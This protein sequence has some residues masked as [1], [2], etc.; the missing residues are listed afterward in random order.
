VTKRLEYER[1]HRLVPDIVHVDAV[2]IEVLQCQ[3]R[4]RQQVGKHDRRSS[5]V[6][7]PLSHLGV[8]DAVGFVEPLESRE[9]ASVFLHVALVTPPWR[10][11]PVVL[12]VPTRPDHPRRGRHQLVDEPG[13][14]LDV[15]GVLAESDLVMCV[16]EDHQNVRARVGEV[17]AK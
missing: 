17:L 1:H 9:S 8:Q 4:H 13:E 2:L 15:D 16:A 14:V 11:L 12:G 3:L 7:E 6:N 5:P 10:L